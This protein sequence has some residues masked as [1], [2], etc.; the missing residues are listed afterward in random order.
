MTDPALESSPALPIPEKAVVAGTV[1]AGILNGKTPLTVMG[2][3]LLVGI[4]MIWPKLDG[5]ENLARD[6]AARLVRLEAR[7]AQLSELREGAR[8]QA[9]L[10]KVIEKNQLGVLGELTDIKR[11]L[12]RLEKP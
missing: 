11:R 10:L 2:L 12:D 8:E 1:L 4:G 3:V 5:I 7:D 9:A 6:N